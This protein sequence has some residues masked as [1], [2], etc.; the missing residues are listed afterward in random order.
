MAVAQLF[1]Q[2]YK[3]KGRGLDSRWGYWDFSFI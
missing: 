2:W 3:P 1:E